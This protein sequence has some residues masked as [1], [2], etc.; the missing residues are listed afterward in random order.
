MTE[1]DTAKI[2]IEW[3]REAGQVNW[4]IRGLIYLEAM[5]MLTDIARRCA[6]FAQAEAH[7]IHHH[8][9]GD[10]HHDH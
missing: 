5:W 2:Y 1:N 7:H 9:E 3:D 8:R 4:N 10:Q 6:E